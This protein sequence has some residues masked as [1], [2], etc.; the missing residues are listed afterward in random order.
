MMERNALLK[1]MAQ[2]LVNASTS[3]SVHETAKKSGVSVFSAK[4]A[5][6]HLY[7]NGMISLK[8]IG[9]T[10]QYKADLDCY[11]TRQWKV[12]F[13]VEGLHAA[14]LVESLLKKSKSISSILL[15]GSAAMGKD[16]ESSD[17]DILIIADV[18]PAVKKG[19]LSLAKG[20][21]RE[22]NIQVYAPSEWRKKATVDKAFYD[23]V[24]VDSII[25]FGQKPVVL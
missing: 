16:D 21:G 20:I 24:I 17:L 11:L 8:K 14:R 18:D 4:H 23:N 5:L 1:V 9:R 15:Y 22:V 25:L 10:Y 7:R 13:S 2:V 19:L 6:D 3:Y 12:L